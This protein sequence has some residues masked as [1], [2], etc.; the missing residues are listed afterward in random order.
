M[1]FSITT[2]LFI[3]ILLLIVSALYSSVGHGGASGYLAVLSFFTFTPNQL[4]TTALIL[5]IVVSG[6]SFFSY[7][8]AGHFLFKSAYPFIIA[9]VPAAF[10]GG[11]M[12][13][14]NK[15]YYFLLSCV[16]IFAAIRMLLPLNEKPGE[17]LSLPRT[18]I[19]IITGGSI[20]ML[21][22]IVGIG[23]GIFL[24]PLMILMKWASTKKTSAVAAFF[25]LVNSTSGLCG[26]YFGDTIEF[27]S[28]LPF[29]VATFIGGLA[30]SYSGANFLSSISLRRILA[31][32]LCI[33]SVKLIIKY[34]A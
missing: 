15:T 12:H 10:L 27:Q 16:L 31:V 5:N 30:G 2:I 9:S 20:G 3:S 8:R 13:I 19:T 32:V 34:F 14:T 28:M 11:M 29:I 6:I 22:G 18:P 23:G 17:N 26:R 1:D 33:A 25:I 7:Y 24:S 21:S 4:A